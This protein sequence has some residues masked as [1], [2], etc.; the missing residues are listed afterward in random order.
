[1]LRGSF[2]KGVG[3]AG[4]GWWSGL[5]V[6]EVVISGQGWRLAVE[7]R[8]A[9]SAQCTPESGMRVFVSRLRCNR[10][11]VLCYLGE[12]PANSRT[13]TH[14]AFESGPPA[15]LTTCTNPAQANIQA[16]GCSRRPNPDAPGHGV[17]VRL[18]A[19]YPDDPTLFPF[20]REPGPQNS[21][22]Q[23]Q[24][25]FP[26]RCARRVLQTTFCRPRR[27]DLE[28]QLNPQATCAI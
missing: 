24:H 9:R 18:S 6:R 4:Q 11:V 23:Q 22:P 26:C 2:C 1:M 27:S 15:R 7:K 20:P 14:L 25:H 16:L 17:A 5:V 10:D 19:L 28:A 21:P 3:I 12:W 8:S 13:R